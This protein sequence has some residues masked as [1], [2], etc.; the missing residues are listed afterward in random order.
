MSPMLITATGVNDRARRPKAGCYS[1]SKTNSSTEGFT[2]LRYS[3]SIRNDYFLEIK[4][5]PLSRNVF[6]FMCI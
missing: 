3:E 2:F 4:L 1:G 6:T 5:V